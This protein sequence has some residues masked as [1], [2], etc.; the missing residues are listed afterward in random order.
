[1]V[2]GLLWILPAAALAAVGAGEAVSEPDIAPTVWASAD[3]GFRYR[4]SPG[5][6]RI[7]AL[8]GKGPV[9]VDWGKTRL[10]LRDGAR[11]ALR[12]DGRV[13]AETAGVVLAGGA[14]LDAGESLAVRSRFTPAPEPVLLARALPTEP[15]ALPDEEQ[16]E[17]RMAVG[18]TPAPPA[19]RPAPPPAFEVEGVPPTGLRVGESEPPD[20]PRLTPRHWGAV[21]LVMAAALL[22]G[23]EFRRQRD[24]G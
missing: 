24:A 9:T 19:A 18:Q 10:H 23:L 1:M 2:P 14:E 22:I 13:V 7:A 20:P 17:M 12:D 4:S 15:Q 5:A 6:V 11:V 8:P 21:A 3:G 16:A